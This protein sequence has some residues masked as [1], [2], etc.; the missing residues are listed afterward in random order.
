MTVFPEPK[1]PGTQAV[2]PS[3]MGKKA[4]TTR[5]PVLIGTLGAK[6]LVTGRG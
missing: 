1:G 2:P 4:S 5:C 3:A 6:R